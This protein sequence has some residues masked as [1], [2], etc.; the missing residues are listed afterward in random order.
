VTEIAPRHIITKMLK[1]ENQGKVLK[2]A[3]GKT[4]DVKH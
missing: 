1:T 3:I 4:K 2:I